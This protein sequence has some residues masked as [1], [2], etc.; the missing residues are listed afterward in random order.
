MN[1]FQKISILLSL[2]TWQIA[3]SSNTKLTLLGGAS[4]PVAA[5]GWVT[6]TG[7]G[8]TGAPGLALFSSQ[9]EKEVSDNVL[10][11]VLA[12]TGLGDLAIVTVTA[13]G[14]YIIATRHPSFSP[15]VEAG[16]GIGIFSWPGYSQGAPAILIGTGFDFKVWPG[17]S[18]GTVMRVN[19]APGVDGLFLTWNMVNC[20]LSL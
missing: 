5:N 1:I 7:L 3:L 2:F 4:E 9:I 12:Q 6:S 10:I 16:M 18:L 15:F 17:A 8:M 20:R 14:R 11:G 19:S 13:S